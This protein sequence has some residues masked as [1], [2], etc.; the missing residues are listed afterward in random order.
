MSSKINIGGI[1]KGHMDTLVDQNTNK[2]SGSDLIYFYIIPIFLP[3]IIV[4]FMDFNF[5]KYIDLQKT[6]VSS[7]AI[8]VGLLFNALVVLINIAKNGDAGSVRK[9]VIQ[10]LVAN[11]SFNILTAFIAVL[12]ILLRFIDMPVLLV[13]HKLPTTHEILDVI[14]LTLL[15]SFFVT[16][17]MIM[18]RTYLIINAEVKEGA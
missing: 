6:I 15:F 11:I 10:E 7:L 1:I 12:F 13:V 8:F 9:K 4:F 16:F 18:K 3:I 5:E 17:L 14:A 2:P